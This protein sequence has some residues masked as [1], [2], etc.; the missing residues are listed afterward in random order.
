[1]TQIVRELRHVK[2]ARLTSSA[3]NMAKIYNDITET[4]GNTLSSA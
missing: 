4:I 3:N 1:M 2:H